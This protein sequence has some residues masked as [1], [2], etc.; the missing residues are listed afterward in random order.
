MNARAEKAKSIFLNAA[1][2]A[3]PTERQA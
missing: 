1:E 3:P 2:V